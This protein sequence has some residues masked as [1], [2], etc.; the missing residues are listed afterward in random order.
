MEC[1][2]VVCALNG[3]VSHVAVTLV[4]SDDQA[5]CVDHLCVD[6]DS[7]DSATPVRGLHN[8]SCATLDDMHTACDTG[9]SPNAPASTTPT[10]TTGQRH[11]QCPYIFPRRKAGARGAGTPASPCGPS[12]PVVVSLQLL[13][14]LAGLPL[15]QAADRIGVS[16][17][18][19]K[20][21]NAL[22]SASEFACER[23]CVCKWALSS[24]SLSYPY[25]VFWSRRA[26]SWGFPS[27]TT[28]RLQ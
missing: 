10:N 24:R 20:K 17:T 9:S 23:V 13:N 8:I 2:P 4:S 18:A 12:H 6:K 15:H 27:G 25:A 1:V 19:F 7:E 16:A 3:A 21:V 5:P 26:A 28:A 11:D 14:T 22:Q